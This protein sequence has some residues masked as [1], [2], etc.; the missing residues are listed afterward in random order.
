MPERRGG[1]SW[2]G[3]AAGFVS[4]V[5]A[6]LPGVPEDAPSAQLQ[7][8]AWDNQGG[9]LTSWAEA[10]DAWLAGETAAGMSTILSVEYIGGTLNVPP[11]LAGLESF[12][13]FVIPEPGGPALLLVFAG[14]RTAS[15]S[16]HG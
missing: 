4:A 2:T 1:A 10:R 8:V 3:F 16:R 12:N 7:M 15:R 13:I 5:T 9:T 14:L 6:T 11:V